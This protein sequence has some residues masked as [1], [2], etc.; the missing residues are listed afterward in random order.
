[1]D[2]LS[3]AFV[4]ALRGPSVAVSREAVVTR[5]GRSQDGAPS[6]APRTS[7]LAI[8]CLAVPAAKVAGARHAR[9]RRRVARLA[10]ASASSDVPTERERYTDAAWQAMQ[11]APGFAQ[12]CQSQYVE[13]EHVFLAALEQPVST[14]GGLAARILEKLGVQKPVAVSRI[15]EPLQRFSTVT[16][17]SQLRAIL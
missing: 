14:T 6:S 12:Q 1:M 10:A 17:S 7:H 2:P 11:D 9:S 8:A 16:L 13:P 3:Q 15:M 5:V 4:P